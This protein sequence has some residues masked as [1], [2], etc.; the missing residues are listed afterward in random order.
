MGLLRIPRVDFLKIDTQGADLAVLRSAGSRLR[1]IAKIT[2]EV[3]VT[4]NRLYQGS[5]SKDEIAVFMQNSGFEMVGDETQSDGQEENLTFA[6]IRNTEKELRGESLCVID[7]AGSPSRSGNLIVSSE[8][9]RLRHPCAFAIGM[10]YSPFAQEAQ[11]SRLDPAA[12]STLA[13][14]PLKSARLFLSDSENLQT[15]P[16]TRNMRLWRNAF[17]VHSRIF[18]CRSAS[19]S[20]HGSCWGTG[21]LTADCSGEISRTR[22]CASQ[23]NS[24]GRVCAFSISALI[25][26]S[27]RFSPQSA[28]DL[29]GRLS[30]SNHLLVNGGFRRNLRLNFSSNVRVEPYALGTGHSKAEL[31]LVEGGEDGCNSLR[32][33]DV[34]ANTQTVSVDVISLDDY[35]SNAGISR[36]DFVKID[37]EGGEREVLLGATGL[38]MGRR[39]RFFSWKF[40]TSARAPGVIPRA[41]L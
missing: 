2:V 17:I 35:L 39:A 33:P 13:A 22:S 9:A 40:R 11:V 41:K 34:A 3:D 37:V 19:V 7:R 20:A 31:F 25:M 28:W 1:D 4:P 15:G 27:T 38:S 14:E 24:W 23:G 10:T 29:L 8:I 5:A 21:C 16:C 36:V 26:D 6:R 12:E 32:P 30:R 18:P